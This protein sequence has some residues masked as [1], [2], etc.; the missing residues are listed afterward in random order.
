[1]LS[2][3][4]ENEPEPKKNRWIWVVT[5]LFEI[6]TVWML[7][8]GIQK[9]WFYYDSRFPLPVQSMYWGNILLPAVTILWPVLWFA[10][11][12]KKRKTDSVILFFC[13]LL[14]SGVLNGFSAAAVPALIN[15]YNLSL[16]AGMINQYLLFIL[17]DLLFSICMMM[18][19]AGSFISAWK[20]RSPKHRYHGE[21]LFL[22]GQIMSKLNTTGKTMSLISI[23]LVLAVFLFIAEPI[24]TGWSSGYLEIRSMYDVQIS[25]RYNEVYEEGNLP[26]DDY[27]IVTDFLV[28]HG[29][30]TE[31]DC[32]FS[33]YLPNRADFHSRVKAD[34]PVAAISLSDYN[35]IREM[36][37]YE[38]ISLEE[39]TFTTQ[40]HSIATDEERDNFLKKHDILR[41]DGGEL[42]LSQQA[43]YEEPI[44]ETVYNSYTDVLYVFPDAVCENLLSVMRN[45]YILTDAM[46]SYTDA[47]ELEHIFTE[48]YPEKMESGV[49]YQVRLRT[50]QINSL[51]ANNFVL[52]ASMIYGA[53]VL[54]VI[55]LT[56]LS[57]QQLFDGNQHRYRFSVL[58]K[59]GVD[60]RRIG[61]LILKQ[62]GVWFGIPV[63]TSLIAAIVVIGYFI[64]S[65]SAEISAYI[66]FHTLL[67]QIGMT[68]A[69]LGILLVCYFISTWI[70]F[71]R[72]VGP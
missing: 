54:L 51:K 34:F 63:I 45:R 66:G 6:F 32:T 33:L 23:T 30:D 19:L 50:L 13:G 59:L 55:C 18:Y 57:L 1:M 41:T 65:I 47:L 24:L 36:L 49:Q 69:I 4:R 15:R 64:Q 16:G 7:I 10:W 52:Q 60:E 48:K 31:K 44:G 39:N 61:K 26:Q 2:A 20:D 17:I 62:L 58:R 38:M 12:G 3:D 68:V 56:I 14:F 25:S 67:L 70:L 9:V 71:R 37:G 42:K 8:V 21:N 35:A 11:L 28:E 43:Y 46:L 22:F 29:I 53:V 27:G 5:I 72:S 40:W